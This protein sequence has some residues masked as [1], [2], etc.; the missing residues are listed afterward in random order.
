MAG[1]QGIPHLSQVLGLPTLPSVS[2][3]I[4]IPAICTGSII[5]KAGNRIRDI[6]LQTGCSISIAATDSTNL[7]ER[8]VTITGSALGV[9]HCIN[10]IRTIVENY[11]PPPNNPAP[12]AGAAGGSGYYPSH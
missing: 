7:N 2:Q 9:Q 6:K 3:K 12:Q 11:T 8:V 10:I 4:A 1:P 5:G